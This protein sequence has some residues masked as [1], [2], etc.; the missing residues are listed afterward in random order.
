MN[1]NKCIINYILSKYLS[2]GGIFSDRPFR[3]RVAA[4]IW[5]G[6]VPSSNGS[7]GNSCQ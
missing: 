2:R 5:D 4:T 3:L 6:L 1:N 7:P